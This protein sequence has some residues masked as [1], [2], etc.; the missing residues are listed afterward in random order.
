MLSG[1]IDI[2]SHQK[3]TNHFSCYNTPFP[4]VEPLPLYYSVGLH[5]WY[6][7]TYSEVDLI[8]PYCQNAFAIG[9]SGIDKLC[10][11]DFFKQIEIFEKHILLSEQYKKPLIIHCVKAFNELIQL[12]QKHQPTQA[13]VIHGFNKKPILTNQLLQHGF[14]LSVG[15]NTPQSTVLEIPLEKL[16]LE[17]DDILEFT[18]QEVYLHVANTLN[19][20]LDTLIHSIEQNLRL[21]QTR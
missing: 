3:A 18:I 2:H 17:T 19:L 20:K 14:Y 11:T 8:K 4:I 5:P 12:K 15:I 10:K 1:Y 16:F 6:L 7:D 9:E 13:W 21:I